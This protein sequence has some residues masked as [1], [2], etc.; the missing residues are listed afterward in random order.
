MLS[1][2]IKMLKIIKE[3]RVDNAFREEIK[4]IKKWH[5]KTFPDADKTGQLLKL[6]E[7]LKECKESLNKETFKE[8]ADVFIVLAG[9]ERYHSYIGGTLFSLLFDKLDLAAKIVLLNEMREKMKINRARKWDKL[10]D[11]RFKHK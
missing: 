3:E 11:G 2:F 8:L 10:K 9:L 4:K 1:K 7:E 6:D 5:I